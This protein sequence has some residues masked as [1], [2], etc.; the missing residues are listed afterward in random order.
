MCE[1]P[2]GI[3]YNGRMATR[4]LISEAPGLRLDP[5][6]LASGVDWSTL[7]REPGPIEIEVGIGKGR[8]LLAAAEARPEVRVM[9]ASSC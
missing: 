1:L 2:V 3:A 4:E 6:E 5:D 7:F 9:L 8:F